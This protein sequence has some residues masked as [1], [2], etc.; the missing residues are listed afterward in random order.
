MI[1]QYL[2]SC[3]PFYSISQ[4]THML[5]SFRLLH[6]T[7]WAVCLHCKKKFI[8]C[9]CV[10]VIASEGGGGLLGSQRGLTIIIL[11]LYWVCQF[12]F[13]TIIQLGLYIQGNNDLARVTAHS[14]TKWLSLCKLYCQATTQSKAKILCT[15]Q[16]NRS[17]LKTC[18][19]TPF[20]QTMLKI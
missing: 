15:C 14:P 5:L 6:Y 17:T 12:H 13:N 1:N 8:V 3:T 18:Q 19:H 9:A 11:A 16:P 4:L 20:S 7:Y 10:H 2:F